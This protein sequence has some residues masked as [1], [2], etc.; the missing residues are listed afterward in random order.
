VLAGKQE[1]AN[2]LSVTG[3]ETGFAEPTLAD[4]QAARIIAV[5]L[6]RAHGKHAAGM[7]TVKADGWNITLLQLR[8]FRRALWLMAA[9]VGAILMVGLLALPP[10]LGKAKASKMR[11]GAFLQV[12]RDQPARCCACL[13]FRR[14]RF[15][16]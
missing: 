16:S 10:E 7:V 1:R 11:Q 13:P 5:S 3:A 12:P 14:A 6:V 15:G 8:G 4:Q 9:L 2:E